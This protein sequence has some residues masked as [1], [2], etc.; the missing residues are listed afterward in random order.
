MR[1][2]EGEP[3]EGVFEVLRKATDDGLRSRPDLKDRD[4]GTIV[5]F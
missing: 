2:G 5:M 4:N 1:R 3:S